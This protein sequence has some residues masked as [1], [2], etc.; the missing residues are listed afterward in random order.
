[1]RHHNRFSSENSSSTETSSMTGKKFW[2]HKSGNLSFGQLWP[3]DLK[4]PFVAHLSNKHQ[5]K[6]T[7]EFSTEQSFDTVYTTLKEAA[8]RGRTASMSSDGAISRARHRAGMPKRGR[9]RRR[10]TSEPFGTSKYSGIGFS[11]AVDSVLPNHAV[12]SQH[13]RQQKQL[14]KSGSKLTLPIGT[15][16]KKNPQSECLGF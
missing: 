8:V 5:H 9:P 2:S 3:T 16:S 11:S 15:I 7:A 1:M 6:N 13:R 12:N 4:L 14:I 10:C